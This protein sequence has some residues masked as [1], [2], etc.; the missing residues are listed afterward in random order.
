MRIERIILSYNILIELYVMINNFSLI[1]HLR[2]SNPSNN[3]IH[4]I[5]IWTG[6]GEQPTSILI[7]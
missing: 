5:D 2:V 4:S 3:L 6:I 7:Y 1:L